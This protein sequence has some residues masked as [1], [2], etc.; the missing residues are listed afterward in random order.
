[1]RLPTLESPHAA[2]SRFPFGATNLRVQGEPSTFPTASWP[3][4]R[5]LRGL[6]IGF[7]DS[8]V[9]PYTNERPMP[10]LISE[11]NLREYQ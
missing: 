1:M 9:L 10:V 2:G 11:R 7:A 8:F 4:G 5:I 6:V 3:L